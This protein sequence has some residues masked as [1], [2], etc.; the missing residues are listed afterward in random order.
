[1]Q[2]MQILEYREDKYPFRRAG[3]S[4]VVEYSEFVRYYR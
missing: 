3:E 1:M 2:N 4:S